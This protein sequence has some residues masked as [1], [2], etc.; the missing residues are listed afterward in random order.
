M[1]RNVQTPLLPNTFYSNNNRKNVRGFRNI[2]TQ[3]Y[4]GTSK[5]PAR[6]VWPGGSNHNF[7]GYGNNI[8]T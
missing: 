4:D 6:G 1:Q 3:S 7:L 5:S 2:M 8:A